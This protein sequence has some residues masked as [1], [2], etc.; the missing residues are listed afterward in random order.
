MNDP[1][2]R[3]SFHRKKL[4][5]HHATPDTLVVD[6][7]GLKHGKFRADIAV[8]NGHLIG[9]EIKSDD[10]SLHRLAQQVEA[11]NAVFDRATAVVGGRHLGGVKKLTPWWWGIMVAMEG[12]RGAIHFET[13]RRAALN[14]SADDFA[15]AQLLW[16]AE[17]EEEL[18]KQGFSGRILRQN[19]SVLYREIIHVLG[20]RELRNV[21]R[22]RL[23][24]RTDWRRPARLSPSDDSSQPYA[25]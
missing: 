15:V 25:T 19:R 9:Y 3:S 11:Y 6:E 22:E 20:P 13:I 4:R 14:P 12:Q 8:I 10:D 24:S 1:Q 2:I 5:R 7:L 23:K 18:V 21:V 17:A 16:R